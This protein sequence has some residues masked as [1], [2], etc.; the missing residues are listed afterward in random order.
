MRQIFLMNVKIVIYLFMDCVCVVDVYRK[1]FECYIRR[2]HT[3]L[4]RLCSYRGQCYTFG[5]SRE[6]R[7]PAGFLLSR[8]RLQRPRDESLLGPAYISPRRG[9]NFKFSTRS[10]ELHVSIHNITI[11]KISMHK[12]KKSLHTH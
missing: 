4:S 12:N 1:C 6:Y 5:T 10:T 8:R 11:P 2:Q 7:P 9:G 3:Q